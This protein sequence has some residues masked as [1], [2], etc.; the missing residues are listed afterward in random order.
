ML[1]PIINY[2]TWYLKYKGVYARARVSDANMEMREL[3]PFNNKELR[4]GP[5]KLDVSVFELTGRK[6]R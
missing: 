4:V 5:S 2:S 3:H 6:A 1:R